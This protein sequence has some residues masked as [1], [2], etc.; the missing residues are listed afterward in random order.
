MDQMD[1]T[2]EVRIKLERPNY[3]IGSEL[4]G[5]SRRDPREAS[6]RSRRVARS[7]YRDRRD[8]ALPASSTRNYGPH[9]RAGAITTMGAYRRR[10]R[11]KKNKGNAHADRYAIM[12][13]ESAMERRLSR[14]METK[15]SSLQQTQ[16][17]LRGALRDERAQRESLERRLERLEDDMEVMDDETQRLRDHVRV[18]EDQKRWMRV[19]LA[20]I[21]VQYNKGK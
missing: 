3:D 20:D 10:Q 21:E 7:G 5:I 1:R 6:P 17:N 12:G 4:R 19:C 9:N 13:A 16:N 15:L 11:K 2:T 18:I 14:A 8:T